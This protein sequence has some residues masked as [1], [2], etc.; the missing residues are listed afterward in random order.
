MHLYLDPQNHYLAVPPA[1]R[2]VATNGFREVFQN[3]LVPRIICD[4]YI[5]EYGGRYIEAEA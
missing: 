2:F 5:R 4:A 3:Q 1:L